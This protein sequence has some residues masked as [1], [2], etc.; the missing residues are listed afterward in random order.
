[1]VGIPSGTS[2]LSL[3]RSPSTVALS[4]NQHRMFLQALG[5]CFGGQDWAN[6]PEKQLYQVAVKNLNILMPEEFAGQHESLMCPMSHALQRGER[7]LSVMLYF[8]SNKN[9]SGIDWSSENWEMMKFHLKELIKH[10]GLRLGLSTSSS[11]NPSFEPTFQAIA[12]SLF[13]NA[14]KVQ[15]IEFVELLLD[16]GVDVNG[17]VKAGFRNSFQPLQFLT[18]W[19]YEPKIELIE[20]LIRRGANVNDFVGDQELTALYYAI[21]NSQSVI[22]RTLISHGATPT[23][24]CFTAICELFN[25]EE[26]YFD[27][28]D[29]IIQSLPDVNARAFPLKEI[30]GFDG[31][32]YNA[33]AIALIHD[34]FRIADT[35]FKTGAIL[36]GSLVFIPSP[37]ERLL[38]EHFKF[39]SRFKF[40]ETKYW[41]TTLGLGI[42]ALQGFCSRNLLLPEVLKA[43][44][45]INPV[46][47]LPANFISP[48]I[49]AVGFNDFEASRLMIEAG[50]NLQLVDL[51]MS[52]SL[53]M[54]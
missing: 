52:C 5:S 42:I 12:E 32:S 14:L 17:I 26:L 46:S 25:G 48:L 33:L 30:Y 35:L 50:I 41:T 31:H 20:L 44:I 43:S 40:F 19:V 6:L 54:P 51:I 36:D 8:L 45:Q 9:S 34:K 21:E 28:V 2:S 24:A 4:R 37:K 38:K 53:N 3:K 23:R 13:A 10:S 16:F 27:L 7:V 1:M 18:K 11:A 15:D 49:F 47:E 39:I 29:R 22:A